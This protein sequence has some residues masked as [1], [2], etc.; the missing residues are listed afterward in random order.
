MTHATGTFEVQLLAPALIR[1][2]C[3]EESLDELEDRIY[4]SL[5]EIRALHGSR[6]YEDHD[7]RDFAYARN[8]NNCGPCPFRGMCRRLGQE[9]LA[10][11][12]PVPAMAMLF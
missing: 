7:I 5:E 3:S 1:H 10:C 8:P 11:A 12:E 9:P 4:R 6:K 2:T